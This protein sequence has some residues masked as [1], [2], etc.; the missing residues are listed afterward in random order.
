MHPTQQGGVPTRIQKAEASEGMTMRECS[1]RLFCGVN[2][3]VQQVLYQANL[4]TVLIKVDAPARLR[5]PLHDA[6]TM[7][8]QSQSCDIGHGQ[9]QNGTGM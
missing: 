8:Q 1:F 5:V 7:L 9:L 6:V 2:V 3:E 4:T